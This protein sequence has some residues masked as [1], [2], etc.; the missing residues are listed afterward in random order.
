MIWAPDQHTPTH[1]AYQHRVLHIISQQSSVIE[2]VFGLLHLCVHW[3]FLYLVLDGSE[4]FIQWFTCRVLQIQHQTMQIAPVIK[5]VFPPAIICPSPIDMCRQ[6]TAIHLLIIE[7]GVFIYH[8]AKRSLTS[9]SL[10]SLADW[11]LIIPVQTQ[12][13]LTFIKYD[14]HYYHNLG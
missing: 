7:Q 6:F 3:A 4:E 14:N 10:T 1:I 9:L 8:N 13:F 12:G 5:A 2:R 11:H